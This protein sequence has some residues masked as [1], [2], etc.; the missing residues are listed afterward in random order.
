VG[1][2]TFTVT[3]TGADGRTTTTTSRYVVERASTRLTDTAVPLIGEAKA[4]L[5]GGSGDVPLAGRTVRFATTT[6][7]TVCL[8]V[9]DADGRASCRT[10]LGGGLGGILD[11]LGGLFGADSHTVTFGG[12]A[13]YLGS[14][15]SG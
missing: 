8:A 6:G 11:K 2:H 10:G 14:T 1:V 4:T 15:S 9:T 5:R 13:E 3:A 7:A 12:D